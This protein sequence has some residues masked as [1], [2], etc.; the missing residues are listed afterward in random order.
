MVTKFHQARKREQ[1]FTLIELMVVVA[2]IGI[3]TAIAVPNFLSY[4]NK[5]RVAAV[6]ASSESV[7]A[8]LANYAADSTNNLYPSSTT[9]NSGGYQNLRNLV[10][11]NGATL[12][13]SG[14]FDVISYE[15]P[16]NGA[17]YKLRIEASNVPETVNGYQILI[18][19]ST[20]IRCTSGENDPCEDEE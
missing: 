9:I 10:N 11:R 2:I 6:L 12:P 15:A 4:R 18:T 1:G 20:I 14:L 7:R 5:S 13:S 16:K 19:P 17:S 8:A 3:L